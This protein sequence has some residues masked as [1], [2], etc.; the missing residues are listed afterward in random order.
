MNKIKFDSKCIGCKICYKACWLD[1]IRWDDEKKR[2]VAAYPEDCIDC[3]FCV[4]Q[5]PTDSVH[6]I[7]DFK[8][9]MPKAY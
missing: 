7:V 9:P 1:V 6:V 4:S 5:C 2:P 8:K 3:M